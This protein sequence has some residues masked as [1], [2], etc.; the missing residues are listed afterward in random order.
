M[1]A[2]SVVAGAQDEPGMLDEGSQLAAEQ[3]LTNIDWIEGDSTTVPGMDLAPVL[4]VM[5]AAFHWMDRDRTLRDLDQLVE[6]DGAVVLSSGGAPGDV[7]PAPWLQII[8]DFRTHCLGPSAEPGRRLLPP[9]GPP[10][11]RAGPQPVLPHRHRPLGPHGH[12]HP[13]RGHRYVACQG[14]AVRRRWRHSRCSTRRAAVISR[15]EVHR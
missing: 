7:E 12:P 2:Y 10:P 3:D 8:A 11:G 13:G 15:F 14:V 1:E 5:G 9:Q 4:T 6:A